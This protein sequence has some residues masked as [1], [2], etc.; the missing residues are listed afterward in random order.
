[1]LKHSFEIM[2]KRRHEAS[3][4]AQRKASKANT[5]EGDES[6][7]EMESEDVNDDFEDSVNHETGQIMR[8]EVENFMCHKRLIVIM[9]ILFA[10]ITVVC[11]I[12]FMLTLAVI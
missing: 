12:G 2:S 11:L 3:S 4:S 10:N 9:Q 5:P 6:D 1:M 7:V 8:V